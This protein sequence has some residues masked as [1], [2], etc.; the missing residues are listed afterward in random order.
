MI[1]LVSAKLREEKKRSVAVITAKRG[2][3]FLSFFG[4]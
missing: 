1:S 2:F 3:I 4:L